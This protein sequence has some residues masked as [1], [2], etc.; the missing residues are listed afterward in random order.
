L[1]GTPWTVDFAPDEAASGAP[2]PAQWRLAP[3][4]VEQAFTHFSLRL[5]V[6]VVRLPGRPPVGEGCFWVPRQEI[7]RVALSSLMRKAVAH[8]LTFACDGEGLPAARR[9]NRRRNGPST[10]GRSSPES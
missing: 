6:Y 7:A 9:V 1:P 4:L 8:A 10:K 5:N 2:F 3:G